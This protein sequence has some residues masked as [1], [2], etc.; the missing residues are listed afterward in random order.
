MMSQTVGSYG[1]EDIMTGEPE[2]DPL[3]V[4]PTKSKT[5]GKACLKADSSH[6]QHA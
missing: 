3:S 1:I 6:G 5:V 2:F 4:C